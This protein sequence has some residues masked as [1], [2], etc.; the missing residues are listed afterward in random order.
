MRG[1]RLTGRS[2]MLGCVLLLASGCSSK[3]VVVNP[4][5]PPPA[6]CVTMTVGAAHGTVVGPGTG[7]TAQQVIQSQGG[8]PCP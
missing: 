7:Q 4:P 8:T 1:T 5:A 6:P 2:A 3:P